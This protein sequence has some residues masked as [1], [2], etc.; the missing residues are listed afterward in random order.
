METSQPVRG[1]GEAMRRPEAKIQMDPDGSDAPN[2]IH[3]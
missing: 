2:G 1:L 3:W